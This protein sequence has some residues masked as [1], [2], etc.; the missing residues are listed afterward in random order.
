LDEAVYE[1]REFTEH[2]AH[3][4]SI[5]PV[6]TWPLL[7]HRHER[8]RVRPYGFESV[9]EQQSDYVEWVLREVGSR[10]PVGAD[11]LP[12]PEGLDRRVVH[13][14]FGTVPRIVLETHFGYG[15]LAVTRRRDD[16]SRTYDL[17]D[18]VIPRQHHERRLD[19]E[20]QQRELLLIAARGHGVGTAEDLADYWRMLI[21]EARA[22]LAELVESGGLRAVRVEGWRQ[23]AYVLPDARV[24]QRIES[25]ALLSPFDPVVWYRPRALRLFDFEYRVEIFFPAAQ[26]RWGCYVLPFL[27]G[28]RLAARVDLRAERRASQLEVRGTSIEEGVD[29]EAV[30]AALAREL[31]TMAEWLGLERV[32][33]VSRKSFGRL[34]AAAVR[35]VH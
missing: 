20:E 22:R 19:H 35:A 28:E 12:G 34:L 23:A 14:W 29:A 4:A 11:D 15:R 2:W 24:P 1:R 25:A 8:Y 9:L 21:R 30:A 5:V 31:K 17:A 27:F 18:R 32:A 26:R 6:E 3:E 10:G 16:F 33:I 13:S 7:R